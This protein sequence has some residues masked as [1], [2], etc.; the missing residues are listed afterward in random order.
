MEFFPSAFK[1]SISCN[2][3]TFIRLIPVENPLKG[4]ILLTVSA[5]HIAMLRKS[6]AALSF[7][8]N[9]SSSDFFIRASS[10]AGEPFSTRYPLEDF[11]KIRKEI[12][13]S[14]FMRSHLNEFL[15]AKEAVRR[16]LLL[17]G[18][19]ASSVGEIINGQSKA[20]SLFS[21][22]WYSR[23]VD[24]SDHYEIVFAHNARLGLPWEFT[25]EKVADVLWAL[26]YLLGG[27]WS[28]IALRFDHRFP[29]RYNPKTIATLEQSLGSKFSFDCGVNAICL[30]RESV[31]KTITIQG[32]SG[33]IGTMDSADCDQALESMHPA[34]N[35]LEALRN[36]FRNAALTGGISKVEIC[37]ALHI[38][39]KQLHRSLKQFG[40]SFRGVC[41]E[42]LFERFQRLSLDKSLTYEMI[43]EKLGFSHKPALH[44]ALRRWRKQSPF[45]FVEGVSIR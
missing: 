22:E 8:L 43:S 30:S 28:P 21:Q 36:T 31:H 20:D 38:H 2:Y 5:Q 32:F 40:F 16:R 42:V 4:M 25:L 37:A 17:R 10:N 18:L 29:K 39:P 1:L 33:Q 12:F 27:S 14:D 45:Q 3:K 24:Y 34:T 6:F 11:L 26:R 13:A 15:K 44:R 9:A 41:D 35:F 23:L 7:P 19:N